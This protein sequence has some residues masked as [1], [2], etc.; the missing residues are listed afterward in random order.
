MPNLRLIDKQKE[1]PAHLSPL[2]L[3]FEAEIKR[4]RIESGCEIADV[5]RELAAASGVSE[6]HLYNYRNGN[7][8]IPG[9]LIRVFC[10]IFKSNALA[11]VTR[12]DELEFEIEGDIDI[13]QMCNRQ[14]RSMLDGGNDFLDAFDDG[15][16]DGHEEIKLAH[17][18]ARIRRDSYRLLEYAQRSRRRSLGN[19]P[20]VAA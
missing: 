10:S 13:A 2:A 20:P 7:T 5:M 8:D 11:D 9:S 17:S 4:V 18:A 19:T 1:F 14:V 16:I 3:T 15:R 6:N 12:C